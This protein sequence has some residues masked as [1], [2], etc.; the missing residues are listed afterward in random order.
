MYTPRCIKLQFKIIFEE[1]P[2]LLLVRSNIIIYIILIFIYIFLRESSRKMC[3]KTLNCKIDKKSGVYV[4]IPIYIVC[5]LIHYLSVL[6]KKNEC[7]PT[8]P[9]RNEILDT[10]L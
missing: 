6:Y 10:Q 3:S 1:A 4:P 2:G 8:N 5:A 9:P 7:M